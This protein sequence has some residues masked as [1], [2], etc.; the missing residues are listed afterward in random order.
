M[1]VEE[2]KSLHLYYLWSVS[3]KSAEHGHETHG[4]KTRASSEH[5]EEREEEDKGISLHVV[6]L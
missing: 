2:E 4:H 1:T 5:E 6:L 3:H